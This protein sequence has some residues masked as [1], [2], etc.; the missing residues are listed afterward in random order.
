[1]GETEDES[2]YGSFVIFEVKNMKRYYLGFGLENNKYVFTF[3][4]VK[5]GMEVCIRVLKLLSLIEVK[6][7]K[8]Y[9]LFIY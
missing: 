2:F 6:S 3:K 5:R 8:H 4:G 1:M 7:T 9:L